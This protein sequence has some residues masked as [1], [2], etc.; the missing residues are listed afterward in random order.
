M[1]LL[2]IQYE[3]DTGSIE[4]WSYVADHGYA[5]G[6]NELIADDDAVDHRDLRGMNVD[7]SA[8]P[9]TLVDDTG[10]TAPDREFEGGMTSIDTLRQQYE[11]AAGDANAA[12]T[13]YQNATTDSERINALASYNLAQTAQF[14]AVAALTIEHDR[15]LRA[16]YREVFGRTPE[17]SQ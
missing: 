5:P 9:P 16:L 8:S 13:Q 6:E 10:Y 1:T 3:P 2:V 17:G 15:M 12:K 11:T 7:V 4:N 14:S